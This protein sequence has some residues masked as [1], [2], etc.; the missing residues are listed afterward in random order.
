MSI[1]AHPPGKPC[2]GREGNDKKEGERKAASHACLPACPTSLSLPLSLFFCESPLSPLACIRE[3]QAR[4]FSRKPMGLECYVG[5]FDML[6]IRFSGL[7]IG[8]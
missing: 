2:E 5:T 3:G 4:R 6:G 8:C 1:H 7:Q